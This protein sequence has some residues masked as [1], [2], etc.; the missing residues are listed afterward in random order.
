MVRIRQILEVYTHRGLMTRIGIQAKHFTSNGAKVELYL[1]HD[2]RYQL[3]ASIWHQAL[4]EV[5]IWQTEE[6]QHLFC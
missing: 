6:H 2:L 4:H 3:R 5:K 1:S